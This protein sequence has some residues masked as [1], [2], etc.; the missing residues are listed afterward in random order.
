MQYKDKI[1]FFLKIYLIVSLLFYVEICLSTER[2]VYVIW[3]HVPAGFAHTD[4]MKISLLRYLIFL[5]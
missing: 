3:F 5:V 2:D 4:D 1:V